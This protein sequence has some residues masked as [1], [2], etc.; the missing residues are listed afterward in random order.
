[1]VVDVYTDKKYQSRKPQSTNAGM[2]TN[3]DTL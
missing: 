3:K 2:Q 1:M